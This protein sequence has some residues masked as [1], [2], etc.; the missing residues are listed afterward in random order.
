MQREPGATS[1][2]L[3]EQD[4]ADDDNADE[5]EKEDNL[6][7]VS[8]ENEEDEQCANVVIA[9]FDKVSRTKSKWRC[10]LKD[11]IMNINGRD[12]LFHTANGEMQF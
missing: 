2:L 7:D 9:Q 5:E 10:H 4:G 6:S 8:S 12:Y 11:G 1:L 3:N